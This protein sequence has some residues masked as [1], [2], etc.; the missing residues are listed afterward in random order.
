M[1]SP[2]FGTQSTNALAT[3]TNITFTAPSGLADGDV[4]VAWI[5]VVGT[6]TSA[7]AGWSV[8]PAMPLTVGTVQFYSYWKR[9]SS[10]GGSYTWNHASA[11][12]VGWIGRY[13][14]CVASGTPFDTPTANTGT[15]TTITATAVTTT[16][17]DTKLVYL[18]GRTNNP[19]LSPPTGMTER[20]D[21]FT[22]TA[23]QDV[24][25]IGSTGSRTQTISPSQAWAAVLVALK[26]AVASGITSTAAITE[27]ADVVGS[28]AKVA[29]SGA[30]SST[31][32]SDSAVGASALQIQAAFAAT[33][34]DTATGSGAI[35]VR[36]SIAAASE[37]TLLSG[38]ALG[39]FGAF[40]AT[41]SDT[42]LADSAL[43]SFG[44]GLLAAA[45]QSDTVTSA[46]KLSLTAAVVAPEV[47]DGI[48]A[49]SELNIFGAASIVEQS[50]TL[51]TVAGGQNN[52]ANGLF[53]QP[54]GDGLSST[55]ALAISGAATGEF[56]DSI[57]SR[58]ALSLTAEFTGYSD[59]ELSATVSGAGTIT[60]QAEIESAGDLLVSAMSRRRFTTGSRQSSAAASIRPPMRRQFHRRPNS[61]AQGTS[62]PPTTQGQRWR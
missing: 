25:G 62:R 7:P 60:G 11:Q 48:S 27:N 8:L 28:A 31:D 38:G 58:A 52:T 42:L 57:A 13:T 14:G 33:S 12:S 56:S 46:A 6:L 17:A 1:A 35:Q 24:S 9:A 16:V 30:L 55:S 49:Q 26:P 5:G 59:D 43:Q 2:V 41:T 34:S 3:R 21:D 53:G 22:Y 45:E 54:D 36:G 15:G 20:L 61:A 51:S 50:D 37:D 4:M 32:T 29:L 19:A 40:A 23:D 47:G 10:E 44:V 39:I 18:S